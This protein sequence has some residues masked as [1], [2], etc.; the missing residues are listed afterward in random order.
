MCFLSEYVNYSGSVK[1]REVGEKSVKDSQKRLQ[2]VTNQGPPV[3]RDESE[4]S[5]A[6]SVK[7][8][9]KRNQGETVFVLPTP[10]LKKRKKSS[11]IDV[12]KSKF[13]K[14]RSSSHRS[15]EE[16]KLLEKRRNTNLIKYKNGYNS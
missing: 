10:P 8:S 14:K 12:S 7:R 16:I 11:D 1:G 13:S 9:K 2:D 15:V 6:I 4:T 5:P 3:K